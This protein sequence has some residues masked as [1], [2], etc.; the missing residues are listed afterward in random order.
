MDQTGLVKIYFSRIG[1][2]E[3]VFTEG[4]VKD[5]GVSVHTCSIVPEEFRSGISSTWQKLGLI[6]PDA[7][8]ASVRKYHFYQEYFDILELHNEGDT[9]IGYYCD[10][11]TPLEKKGEHYYLTDLLLDIWIKPDRSIQELDW[12]EFDQ[13][14]KTGLLPPDLEQ[15]ARQTLQ[16]IK[17]EVAQGIFPERYLNGNA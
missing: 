9:L 1:K 11:A 15:K 4:L 3:R 6:P 13:A 2:T 10:I 8:I 14:V 5:D 17:A 12:D 16:R 7:V